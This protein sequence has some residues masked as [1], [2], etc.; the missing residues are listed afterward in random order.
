M[1]GARNHHYL[2]QCYLKGFAERRDKQAKLWVC[3]FDSSK[4]FNTVPRNVAAK[5][6]FN[7]VDLD[8]LDPNTLETGLAGF[9]SEVDAALTRIIERQSIA[10]LNDLAY[11]LNLICLIV[12]RHPLRRAWMARTEEG[13][14]KGILRD[15]V[16]NK[17]RWQ[18]HVAT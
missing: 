15:V 7:R 12:I 5:R 6:D 2:P 14:M 11:L 4:Q 9:E 16:A 8:G 3:D 13:M 17:E 1:A 18:V 10:D